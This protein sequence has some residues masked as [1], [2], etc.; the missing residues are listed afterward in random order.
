MDE[1]IA[2]KCTKNKATWIGFVI[3]IL[4]DDFTGGGNRLK[5]LS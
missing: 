4:F 1:I 3:W 5:S 2:L